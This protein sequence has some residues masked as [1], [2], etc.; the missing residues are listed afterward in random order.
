MQLI[1]KDCGMNFIILLKY[2]VLN[3]HK[4]RS[5]QRFKMVEIRQFN[6]IYVYVEKVCISLL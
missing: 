2:N 1:Y 6:S 4:I 3:L 5:N